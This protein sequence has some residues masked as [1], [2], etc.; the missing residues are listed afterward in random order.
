MS[1]STVA[2]RVRLGEK[3][4][5]AFRARQE[6]LRVQREGALESRIAER[7]AQFT[8]RGIGGAERLAELAGRC[9]VLAGMVPESRLGQVRESLESEVAKG[10][11][12]RVSAKLVELEREASYA[13]A[14]RLRREVLLE[15]VVAANDGEILTEIDWAED[16]SCSAIVGFPDT[17]AIR[18]TVTG[19][20]G[21]PG[22][23]AETIAWHTADSNIASQAA[24]GEAE[25]GCAAELRYIGGLV[26]R[27]PEM[28]FDEQSLADAEAIAAEEAE[29]EED[30]EEE[31]G[32]A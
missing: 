4:A 32:E 11:A 28:S 13:A 20:Y 18:V 3:T 17:V 1:A 19:G 25:T 5:Q 14:D 22:E 6:E 10:D 2:T 29:E 24:A 30:W 21:E 7:R 27:Y 26:D 9:D 15:A 16:G 8:E 31:A 12:E 23:E